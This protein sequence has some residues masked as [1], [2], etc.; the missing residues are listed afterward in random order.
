MSS[1]TIRRCTINNKTGKTMYDGFVE[2]AE[3]LGDTSLAAHEFDR[4]FFRAEP[5]YKGNIY[6]EKSDGTPFMA[7]F[8]AEIGSDAQGT[9]LA[10]YP[11]KTPP[12]YKLPFTDVTSKSH[13]QILALRC[14]T[15]APPELRKAFRNGAAVIDGVRGADETQEAARGETFEV[16]EAVLY[17]QHEGDP[18]DNIVVLARLHPTFEVP[19]GSNNSSAPRT[20]RRRITKVDSTPTDTSDDPGD[21]DMEGSQVAER[22]VGDT[23]PPSMLP[24]V[25]GPFYALDK[26]RLFQRDYRDVDNSLIAPHELTA[27]LTEG[28]LVLVMISFATYVIT[29][30]KSER[31]EPKPDKKIYH[32]QVDKL[33]ILDPGNGEPSTPPAPKMPERR[34]SPATPSRKRAR[35]DAA[36][37]AFDSFGTKSSSPSPPKKSRRRP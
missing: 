4:T 20:P 7:S 16:T 27:K 29:D 15:E 3:A 5:D 28:T 6:Y 19:Q 12:L 2:E 34:F 26:A 24:E 10:A 17:E 1:L 37:A 21:V 25:Q 22:K 18:T 11:K 13:R 23:Y 36:D 8:I 14:P 30:Q 32:V 9:W 31:G 33:R 35:D